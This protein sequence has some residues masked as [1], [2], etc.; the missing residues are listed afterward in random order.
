MTIT[1]PH[2]QLPIDPDHAADLLHLLDVLAKVLR[3]SG[4]ELRDDITDRY[5]PS[6]FNHPPESLDCHA[7]LIRRAINPTLRTS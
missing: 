1:T 7:G 4:D 5:T 2:R 6:T 3:H